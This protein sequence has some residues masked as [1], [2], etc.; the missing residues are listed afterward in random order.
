MI[1][2]QRKITETTFENPSGYTKRKIITDDKGAKIIL[3]DDDIYHYMHDQTRLYIAMIHCISNDIQFLCPA[4]TTTCDNLVL[5]NFPI[6][7]LFGISFKDIKENRSNKALKIRSSQP[8]KFKY[9]IEYCKSGI[10]ATNKYLM[11]S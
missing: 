4:A 11:S 1:L 2:Q 5:W 7:H 3:A 10:G 6:K 8:P 9:K